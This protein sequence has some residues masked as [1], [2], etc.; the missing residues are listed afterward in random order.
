M[1][2]TSDRSDSG[3]Q[4]GVIRLLP[5]MVPGALFVLALLLPRFMFWQGKPQTS[6]GMGPDVWPELI[7]GALAAFSAIWFAYEL[8]VLGR[9]GR[10]SALRPPQEDETYH[11]GK[12]LVGLVLILM[13]GAMLQRTGFALTTATFIA[14]WC[15]NGGIRNPLVV[16]PVSLIG[17]VALL[18]V[19]MGLALMP[20]SRGQGAFD[21]FSIWLLQMLGIY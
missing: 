19:F 16:I 2:L 6:H 9:A 3:S 5:A 12:A 11:F 15:V 10:V 17:T 1:P 14:V 13:F 21:Q 18:W 20:L 4:S 7:L 8:W